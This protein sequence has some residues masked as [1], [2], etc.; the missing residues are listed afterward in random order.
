MKVHPTIML[1]TSVALLLAM[2]S[3]DAN[4]RAMFKRLN[5]FVGAGCEH[6][7]V[8]VTGENSETVSVLFS[9][10]DAGFQSRS[11][12]LH[13]SCEF[14][15]PVSIPPGQRLSLLTAEWQGYAK[16]RGGFSRLYSVVGPR[17]RPWRVNR[18]N[19]AEGLNYLERDDMYPRE[20]N[21][22]CNGGEINIR[23][24]S[25]IIAT[26]RNSYIAV[27]TVDL[28]NKVVFRLNVTPCTP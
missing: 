24:K 17:Q 2:Q 18:Y 21:P 28:Q 8:A 3:A 4:R 26:G 25:D 12:A 16:G 10:Y 13:S 5:A 14:S 9:N 23:I 15:L 1:L 27:D 22:N 11:G 19:S 20:V 6:A 7:A